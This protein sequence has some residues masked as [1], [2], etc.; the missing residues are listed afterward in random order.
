MMNIRMRASLAPLSLM[1]SMAA[2]CTT[3][4]TGVG[5]SP[6]GAVRATFMWTAQSARSG[7]MTATL[8]TGAA[9]RG[10][11]FQVTQETRIEDL[12]PLWVGWGRRWRW[13]G[14]DYW[15]PQQ[16]YMTQ[17]TGR[18]LANLEGPDGRMRCRFTLAH[19]SAGM[20]GGGEGRCQLPSGTIIDADFPPS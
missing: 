19:P 13:H 4:G 15:G 3:T 18:V 11:F 1:M 7:T 5:S 10:P 8:N 20:A 2:G 12:A 9:Y 17:Y 14:W 6:G 16:S